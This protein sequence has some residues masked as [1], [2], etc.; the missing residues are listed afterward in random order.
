MMH[1]LPVGYLRVISGA[2][3]APFLSHQNQFVDAVTQF[4]EPASA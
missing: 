2:S 4:L 1:N 3:H